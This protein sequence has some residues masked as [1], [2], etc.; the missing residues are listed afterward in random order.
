MAASEASNSRP[1][2]AA[3]CRVS[4]SGP[5]YNAAVATAKRPRGRTKGRTKAETRERILSAAETCF[6]TS[7][8]AAATNRQIADAAGVT[9]AAIYQHF[10]SKFDLYIAVHERAFAA[11]REGFERIPDETT[12]FREGL[13]AM[14]ELARQLTS[15]DPMLALFEVRAPI[16]AR[17][18]PD[19]TG[20]VG[21]Y[22]APV[23]ETYRR[24]AERG[25]KSGEITEKNVSVIV[26]GVAAMIQGLTQSA[27]YV[28]TTDAWG[29][30]IDR[31]I[32]LVPAAPTS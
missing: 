26:A 1:L 30:L 11:I 18:H 32:D 3:I 8:Y 16:E 22:T 24:I 15:L 29:E 6:A 23:I 12:T 9:A 2:D 19:L 10:P 28:E 21:G 5:P 20:V 4:V 13:L 7:G 14:F 31:Y 27:W 17:R 25:V